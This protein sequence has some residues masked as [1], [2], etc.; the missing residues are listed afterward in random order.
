MRLVREHDAAPFALRVMPFLIQHEAEN[1]LP[2]GVLNTLAGGER[3]S[4]A[5]PYLAAI[6][7]DDGAVVATAIATPPYNLTFSHIE[8]PA[9]ADGIA[10]LIAADLLTS[11]PTLNAVQAFPQLADAFA[12]RWADLSGRCARVESRER[13]YQLG[14]VRAICPIPGAMRRAAE[15]DRPLVREWFIAFNS[16]TFGSPR[17]E[18]VEANIERRLAFGSSGMYLWDD[19]GHTV[20]LAGYSGPTPHGARVGPVYTPPEWRGHGYATALVANLSQRLLDEGR[21]KLFLFTDL[22]NPTSN[23]IYTAIGYQPVRDVV[24]VAFDSP[25]S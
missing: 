2:I 6:I 3:Y 5:Q 4:A 24:V 12:T 20:S 23:H 9:A 22:S 16:E 19:D 17:D 10:D 15:T 8:D 7:S 14:A 13:I 25:G 18:T 11:W 1:C 21:D